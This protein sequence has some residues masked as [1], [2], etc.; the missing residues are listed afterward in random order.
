MECPFKDEEGAA[1]QWA[2][3]VNNDNIDPAQL[4][5]A[6]ERFMKTATTLGS[7]FS[8]AYW[9][10]QATEFRSDHNIETEKI[11]TV[12]NLLALEWH[13]IIDKARAQWQF[14]QLVIKQSQFLRE[15]LKLIRNVETVTQKI[16]ALGFDPSVYFD[17]LA[18][19]ELK[20]RDIELIKRW[21]IY[22][23]H[24]DGVK[25][26][27]K[28][29]GRIRQAEAQERLESVKVSYNIEVPTLNR[30]SN[31][32]IV[33]LKLG[34]DIENTIPSELALLSDPDSSLLFDLKLIES[35][36]MCFDMQGI[37][38]ISEKHEVI[39]EHFA[40]DDAG[41]GP[42]IICVDTSASMAGEAEAIAKA[43]TLFIANT[44]EKQKRS[45][46]LINF[47]TKL[48]Y[49]D[50]GKGVGMESLIKF[51]KMSFSGGTDVS[52]AISHAIKVMSEE[53]Y[54]NADLLVI[55]DFIM[56]DIPRR[57]VSKIENLQENGN[58]FYSLAIMSTHKSKQLGTLFDD[59][60]IFDPYT[61]SVKEFVKF[62]QDFHN[63]TRSQENG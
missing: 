62:K 49:F 32:E 11:Y 63:R 36:L 45:C 55:S 40:K 38:F 31:E 15:M 58:R 6:I 57:I 13:K 3:A 56:A 41:N 44:A 2:E 50:V 18:T 26:L 24:D 29:L 34:N 8:Q 43:V 10:K 7:P 27:C 22:L 46:Y 28:L 47:S 51:L 53:T 19:G 42:F 35:R 5:D 12:A 60:W 48:Q 9:Y 20:P 23:E 16:E 54:K 59:E 30:N 4:S 39:E 21:S 52:P 37:D 14:E 33:G 25:R 61:G 1:T 17:P